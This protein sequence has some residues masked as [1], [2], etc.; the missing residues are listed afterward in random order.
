VRNGTG[1]FETDQLWPGDFTIDTGGNRVEF[2]TKPGETEVNVELAAPEGRREIRLAFTP[3]EDALLPRGT[4]R[5]YYQAP[6]DS[7]ADSYDLPVEHGVVAFLARTGHQIRYDPQ[8]VV[9]GWFRPGE[10]RAIPAGEG[11][12]TIRIPFVPAGAIAISLIEADG[13]PADGFI[14]HVREITKSPHRGKTR[15][16]VEGKNWASHNDGVFAYTATPLPLGG[17]Y[18]VVASRGFTYVTTGP[19]RLTEKCPLYK[20][21][22]VLA[23]DATIRG[24]VVDPSGTPL[25]GVAVGFQLPLA[26]SQ[27]GVGDIKAD[28]NGR[29]KF[30]G[31][32]S[33]PGVKYQITARP[34]RGFVP[35]RVYVTDLD[36]PL[37]IVT[38][39]GM[40]LSGR[41]LDEK[42]GTPLCDLAVFLYRETIDREQR[43]VQFGAEALTDRKG[44]FRFSNLLPGTYSLH[45]SEVSTGNRPRV[46][47]GQA[48]PVIWRVPKPH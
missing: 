31:V 20:R 7:Y 6:K 12:H 29:F 37:R 42:D 34:K 4:V 2:S 1:T 35:R 5:V 23:G 15:F 9:G 10:T 40:A 48:K 24:Q 45:G 27:F 22:L 36:K 38:K 33:H 11:P 44:N 14:A 18:E 13:S 3:R 41:V 39:P 19:I 28:A 26:G 43:F 25:P 30:P 8:G 47:A 17:T 46:K 21:Q 32:V 16:G